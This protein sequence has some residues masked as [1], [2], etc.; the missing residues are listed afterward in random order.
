[1]KSLCIFDREGA[2]ER[3]P[4]RRRSA[5]RDRLAGKCPDARFTRGAYAGG[6]HWMGRMTRLRL[7][8]T[9]RRRARRARYFDP[10]KRRV[11]PELMGSTVL[12][13]RKWMDRDWRQ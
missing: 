3:D 5:A 11:S 8:A 2:V 4:P 9:G 12:C 1:M 10:V 13:R 6:W 7:F